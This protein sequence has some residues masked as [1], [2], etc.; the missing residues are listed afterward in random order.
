MSSLKPNLQ[1][2]LGPV[3][4]F[5]RQA[6]RTRDL[7]SGSYILSY[8]SARAMKGVIDSGGK[9]IVPKVW[10][11]TKKDRLLAWVMDERLGDPPRIGT[12]PNRFQAWADNPKEAAKAAEDQIS[13]AWKDIASTVWNNFVKDVAFKHGSHTQ[14]IWDRQV[15]NFW[16]IYWTAG[17]ITTIESRKNWRT[18]VLWGRQLPE[19]ECGDHCTIMGEWQELSGF[20]RSHDRTVRSRQNKFWECMRETHG[21]GRLDFR[22]DERLCSIALIKRMFPKRAKEAI[23]W[24]VDADRWPSTLYV[25][26]L[27]WLRGIENKKLELAR[28]YFDLVKDA[29]DEEAVRRKGV[30]EQVGG[31]KDPDLLDFLEL[32]GNFYFKSSVSNHR[33][34]PLKR[35][36]L[37]WINEEPEEV[38]EKRKG[39]IKHLS[40]LNKKIG[41][42]PSPFYGMLL[43][44]GDSMGKLLVDHGEEVSNALAEFGNH[45]DSTVKMFSGVTIYAGGDDVLA[46]L[47]VTSGVDCAVELADH[48]EDAF[49]DCGLSGTI[50]AGLVLAHGRH[51]LRSVLDEAHHILGRVAKDGNGRQSLAVSVLK[52]SGKYCQWVATFPSLKQG[53]G[54][55]LDSLVSALSSEEKYFSTSFFFRMRDILTIL[56]SE[57]FW[58]PGSFLKLADEFQEDDIV[59]LLTAEY[60]KSE[61][62]KVNMDTA[63][64]NVKRLLS[65]SYRCYRNEQE[66]CK[67]DRRHLSADGAMLV[68]FLAEGGKED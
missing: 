4:G 65:I 23:G 17:D 68:K 8:L 27:P 34:T 6:R 64:P 46:M 52:G 49:S 55:V 66:E 48:F 62:G 5:I 13:K 67:T 43:M 14:D 15:E 30:W 16:E 51:P 12:I 36:P 63:K 24:D 20:T 59:D 31:S 57:P 28:S 22:E 42:E 7:W 11:D 60:L 1:F 41:R 3:Q 40:K 54:T 26:A 9:I 47:P 50:S 29:A 38:K 37:K 18:R 61:S 21:V 19:L 58:Q 44:D 45:V 10:E 56:S 32:D 39:L 35:T 33:H 2:S 53:D 25:A